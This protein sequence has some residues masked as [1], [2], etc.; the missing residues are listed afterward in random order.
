MVNVPVGSTKSVESPPVPASS[1]LE[2][3]FPNPFNV[4]T[5]IAYRLATAGPVR[6]QIYN[7]L[8]QLQLVTAKSH[9]TEPSPRQTAYHTAAARPQTANFRFQRHRTHA[10]AI[11]ITG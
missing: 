9:A 11:C 3:N 10:P 5:Q 8:G 1:G 4:G 7:L 2:P 6:L